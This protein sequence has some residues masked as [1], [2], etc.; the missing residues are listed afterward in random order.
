MPAVWGATSA[1]INLDSSIVWLHEFRI[2]SFN[3]FLR[4]HPSLRRAKASAW[5]TAAA[6]EEQHSLSTRAAAQEEQEEQHS[7]K[8]K[9]H[10]ASK[11]ETRHRLRGGAQMNFVTEQWG[12]YMRSLDEK[13]FMT[14]MMTGAVLAALGDL[15]AQLLEGA[16]SIF[17]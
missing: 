13:P 14:K 8:H 3:Q 6:Q 7:K 15:I 4:P 1:T 11:A 9:K 10:N 5:R 17:T 12:R 16:S 2:L